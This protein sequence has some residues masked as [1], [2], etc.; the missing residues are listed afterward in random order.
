MGKPVSVQVRPSAPFNFQNSYKI[1]TMNKNA[2]G[3]LIKSIIVFAILIVISLAALLIFYNHYIVDNP[4]EHLSKNHII[5][6]ISAE[7]PVYFRDGKTQLGTF[8]SEEHR[9]WAEISK[10][11]KF[12]IDAIIAAEDKDFFSHPGF[13]AFGIAG[14]MLKNIKA[15]KVVAGGSTITQQTA[16]NIYY[17]QGRTIKAKLKE[18]MNAL[19]LEAKYSKKEI[20]E[21]YINQFHVNANGRGLAIAA[22]YFFDKDYKDLDLLESAFLAGLVKGPFLYNPFVG[23]QKRR[24]KA[25]NRARARTDYVLKRM[26]EEGYINDKQY[27]D[28]MKRDI[29]FK[30]GTFR[31]RE[32]SALSFIKEHINAT[33]IEEYLQE[34]GVDN[35]STAGLKIITTLDEKA[36]KAAEY[37]LRHSLT[38]VGGQIEGVSEVLSK[39]K[40]KKIKQSHK[41]KINLFGFYNGV[42]T[43]SPNKDNK[44]ILKANIGG[45]DTVIV[46]KTSLENLALIEKKNK[47]AA[48][49]RHVK[50]K[51]LEDFAKLFKKKTILDLSIFNTKSFKSKSPKA[52]IELDVELEGAAVILHKGEL[53]AM[54]G[55]RDDKGYNRAVQAV[56]Q[57]GSTFKPFISYLALSLGWLPTDMISN[58]RDVFEFFNVNYFPRPDH[59]GAPPDVSIAWL[60]AKSENLA[61]VKLLYTLSDKLTDKQFVKLAASLDMAKRKDE[62]NGEFFKRIGKKYRVY[63]NYKKDGKLSLNNRI[64]DSIFRLAKKEVL[65]DLEFEAEQLTDFESIELS[66]M[67]YGKG[68]EKEIKSVKRKTLR[69][70]EKNTRLT[71]LENNFLNIKKYIPNFEKNLKNIEENLRNNKLS[72]KY[73]ENFF[74][75]KTNKY[76]SFKPSSKH[77]EN[78]E[79]IGCKGLIEIF[80]K[81]NSVTIEVNNE[82]NQEN[83]NEIIKK[84]GNYLENNVL[85]RGRLTFS[86]INMVSNAIEKVKNKFLSLPKHSPELLYNHHDFIISVNLEYAK[87][88]AEELGVKTPLRRILSFP[89]GSNEINLIEAAL[90]YQGITT[91]STYNFNFPSPTEDTYPIAA[92]LRIEDSEGNVLYEMKKEEIEFGNKLASA[93]LR[94]MLRKVVIHGTGRRARKYVSLTKSNKPAPLSLKLPLAGKTGTTNNYRNAAFFWHYSCNARI[95]RS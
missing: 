73:C 35:F 86:T 66:A 83:Q 21:F 29:P 14:A 27:I 50:E 16:K 63:V 72:E 58:R 56:R 65:P 85:I 80:E 76:I 47:K 81:A 92:I 52:D 4:G 6:V 13:S 84:F 1:N 17:R 8:F 31:F 55:G 9:R 53:M 10:T 33:G 46:D 95:W 5:Q 43:E 67:H 71:I 26:Y 93:S 78:Y 44:F 32:R 20:L 88:V 12:Y 34:Q 62:S 36:Q 3:C 87:R 59:K 19:R 61:A 38:Q 77:I 49:H 91:A 11:P 89:L 79:K 2:K 54:T 42:I 41:K 69:K 70:A 64:M 60:I 23:S 39:M 15:G 94:D 37:G 18:L 24:E 45:N 25:K 75:H 90:L 82:E 74:I 48:W 68:F 7:S 30:M 51:E 40:T 57:F 22:K 28:A